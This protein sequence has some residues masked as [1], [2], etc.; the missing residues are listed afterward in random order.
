MDVKLCCRSQNVETGTEVLVCS[1]GGGGLL[2][3]RMHV[4][5]HLWASNIKVTSNV[6]SAVYDW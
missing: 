3:E 4:V 2:A 5:A 1:R 6:F